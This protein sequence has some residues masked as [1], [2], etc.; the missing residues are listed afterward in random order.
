MPQNSKNNSAARAVYILAH[1]FAVLYI[2]TIM[3]IL[4]IHI[5]GFPLFVTLMPKNN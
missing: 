4:L 2:T 3:K 1:I 5:N